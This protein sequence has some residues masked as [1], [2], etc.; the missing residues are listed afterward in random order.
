MAF[1]DTVLTAYTNAAIRK[2]KHL[3]PNQKIEDIG[4]D[5]YSEIVLDGK[6]CTDG[7]PCKTYIRKGNGKDLVIMFNG[8]GMAWDKE[9]CQCGAT[10]S[11]FFT[12]KDCLYTPNMGPISYFGTFLAS[13]DCGIFYNNSVN[14]FASW[15]NVIIQYASGDFHV[16]NGEYPYK[17]AKG[18]DKMLYFQGYEN[19]KAAMKIVKELFPN[20]ERIL[21]GG[22]SAGA[23][24]VS[25]LAGEIID[26]YPDCKNITVYIDAS[27]LIRD[28][29]KEI[30]TDVWKAPQHIVDMVKTDD[31]GSDWLSALARKYGERAKILYTGTTEDLA[32]ATYSRYFKTRV[33]KAQDEDLKNMTVALRNRV[34]RMAA[35]GAKIHYYICDFPDKANGGTLHCVCGA[36]IWH[37]GKMEGI[38]PS[39]WVMNA[40]N[41]N[42]QNIG[43]SL[44]DK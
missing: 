16:G 27:I 25:A 14:P 40:V 13:K 9:S 35:E 28:D 8:G 7:T 24:G 22:G 26:M 11:R 19:F 44:L 29:W 15:D 30:V 4:K 6:V 37:E 10:F 20:P 18:N 38:S 43:L 2:R 36:P 34:E 32:L 42:P 23:F 3:V 17:D 39:E 21:L 31:L 33:F 41:G 5:Y 1:L 12:K